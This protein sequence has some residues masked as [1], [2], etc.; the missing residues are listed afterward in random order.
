M[1]GSV[2]ATGVEVLVGRTTADCDTKK[3][4]QG[5]RRGKKYAED[6]TGPPHI[7]KKKTAG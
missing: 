5:G 1:V 6:P 3:P 4:R 2:E 7:Q